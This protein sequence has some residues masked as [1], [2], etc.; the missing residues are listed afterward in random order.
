[1]KT[2]LAELG[3]YGPSGNPNSPPK[4]NRYTEVP[5]D[6]IERKDQEAKDKELQKSLEEEEDRKKTGQNWEL[7]DKNAVLSM[8]LS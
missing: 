1:L 8:F 6:I 2:H 4:V 5:W 3:I 7:G